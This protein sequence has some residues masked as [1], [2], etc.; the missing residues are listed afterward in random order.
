[1]VNILRKPRFRISTP[2]FPINICHHFVSTMQ[3]VFSLKSS[4]SQNLSSSVIFFR[5]LTP[6]NAYVI[7]LP[8]L[9]GMLP[10]LCSLGPPIRTKPTKTRWEK[11]K[12]C[13]GGQLRFSQG[14]LLFIVS[15]LFF[16]F[17]FLFFIFFLFYV[18]F[19]YFLYFIFIFIFLFVKCYW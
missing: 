7:C 11:L 13:P 14:C 9:K 5:K 3:N 6:P 19:F 17:Y 12:N 16:I 15:F 4:G 10:S 2:T 8:S 1:M 18:F